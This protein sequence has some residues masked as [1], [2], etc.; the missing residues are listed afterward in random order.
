MI[1]I[2][3]RIK[4]AIEESGISLR[5][6]EEETGIERKYL[7]IIAELPADEILLHE[8][9]LIAN[10]LGKRTEDLFVVKHYEIR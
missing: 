8:I 3:M 2:E 10:A 4:E 6:L 9:V 7:K 5:E 1:G